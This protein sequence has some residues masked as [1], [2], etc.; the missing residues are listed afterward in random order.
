MAS[1]LDPGVGPR[2]RE[3]HVKQIMS[4]SV[5][6]CFPFFLC[7][8]GSLSKIPDLLDLRHSQNLREPCWSSQSGRC[9]VSLLCP[10]PTLQRER[11]QNPPAEASLLGLADLVHS[12]FAEPSS[13]F[14][15]P[16]WTCQG[17]G[18]EIK[19]LVQGHRVEQVPRVPCLNSQGW[20]HMLK[21]LWHL[22][23]KPT[24]LHLGYSCGAK[25]LAYMGNRKSTG[26]GS[27]EFSI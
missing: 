5:E 27:P 14:G 22:S 23:F 8:T 26:V 12:D 10:P 6:L 18:A 7:P 24:T 17:P 20:P 21:G 16:Q 2:G 13:L 9:V 25:L 3:K 1:G 15:N 11:H 19:Q 4:A